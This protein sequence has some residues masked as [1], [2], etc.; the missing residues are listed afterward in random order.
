MEESVAAYL[1]PEAKIIAGGSINKFLRRKSYNCCCRGNLLLAN[2]T[3]GSHLERFIKDINIP[4]TNLLE[5]GQLWKICPRKEPS[6]LQ[7]M[8]TIYDSY[9]EEALN[10]RKGKTA[11]FWMTYAKIV[12]LIEWMKR[13]IKIN[14]TL[15]IMHYYIHF[16]MRS[17]FFMTSHHNYVRWMSLYSLDLPNL[18]ASQLDLQKILTEADFSLNRTGKSFV[19]VSLLKWLLSKELMQTQRVGWRVLWHLQTSTAVNLWI[20]TASK[21]K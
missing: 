9:L 13:A 2:A 3:Y 10:G 4:S 1:L 18:E 5:T 19:G 21:E 7:D 15:Y 17:S 12:V 20:M 14:D 16:E 8:A 11:Q 6:N